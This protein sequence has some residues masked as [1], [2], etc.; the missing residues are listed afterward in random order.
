MNTVIASY[1]TTLVYTIRF[2]LQVIKA[3]AIMGAG[4]L[5]SIAARSPTPI[6]LT[7]LFMS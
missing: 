5:S 6:H 4:R 2:Q 3:F 1:I 7:Q